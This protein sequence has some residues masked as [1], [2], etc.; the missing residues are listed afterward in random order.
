MRLMLVTYDIPD[1][2]RRTRVFAVLSGYGQRLQYSVF[3]L[4][5]S[6]TQVARL[7][8]EL[9]T[10]I[11]AADDQILFVDIGPADGRGEAAVS[12]LGRPV[13]LPNRRAVVI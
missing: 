9:D 11:E 4:V 1:D 2:K 10:I 7:R 5:A 6:D 3:V 12:A 8:G 13:E